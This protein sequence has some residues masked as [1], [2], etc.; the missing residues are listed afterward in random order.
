MLSSV[1][2]IIGL[3]CTL[4]YVKIQV[5]LGGEEQKGAKKIEGGG[6]YV[7]AA[8]AHHV[9]L[10]V[11]CLHHH[12]VSSLVDPVDR[13]LQ[14]DPVSKLLGHALADLTGAAL[15]LP[16]LQEWRDSARVRGQTLKKVNQ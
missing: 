4:I 5:Q 13:G 3:K 1:V 15:K 9:S 16:L 8:V 6:S 7:C 14:F 12:H 10:F 11:H 2:V